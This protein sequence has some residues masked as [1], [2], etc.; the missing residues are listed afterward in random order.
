M[1]G[2]WGLIPQFWWTELP[3]CRGEGGGSFLNIPGLGET[4]V[5]QQ[6]GPPARGSGHS[7]AFA[8]VPSPQTR[9]GRWAV[10]GPSEKHWCCGGALVPKGLRDVPPTGPV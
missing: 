9:Q 4:R 1:E 7:L 8:A 5:G 2:E 10:K 3:V 6:V